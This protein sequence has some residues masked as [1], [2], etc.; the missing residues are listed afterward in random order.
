MT[1]SEQARE[2]LVVDRVYSRLDE[3]RDRTRAQLARVRRE[4][5]S[6]THQNR[7]ERDSFATLYS[8]RIAQLDAVE[9][10]LVF[11]RLD[12]RDEQSRY[13]GRIGLSDDE[14]TPVLTDWRAPAARPFYQATAADP[15]D[16]VRRR[17]LQTR[18]RQVVAVEDDV[19][20][21]D[22]LDDEAR[23]GLAGEGALLAAL[24]AHRT[25]RMSDIVAT[26]QA[27]QD[28]VIRSPLDG[29][30]VVQGG[31]GTG[32]TAVALHRAAY[33]LYAHR[34]RLTRS[35]V[36][37]LGPSDVFLGYISKV[38]PA[39]GETGVVSTTIADL[40]PGIRASA[41][42]GEVAARLKGDA[43][44]ARVIARAVRARQRVPDAPREV[45][46]G[47]RTLVVHP[48][49]V[50]AAQ[51]RARRSHAPHNT[52]RVTFVR[53]MLQTLARQYAEQIGA[54]LAG[55]ELA[56]VVED[57]RSARD[58]RVALNLAWM[59]LTAT[60]LVRDLWSRPDRLAEA[61]PRLSAA[62]REAL[63]RSPDAPWTEADVP[64]I[65]EAAELLGA[66]TE[67]ERAER[68][69]RAEAERARED[70]VAYARETIRSTGVGG[71]MVTAEM[72]AD[73]F[74]ETGPSL[75]TAE[76][77]AADR[78]WT[79]GHVVVDE[80]QELSAMAWR[81]ILRRCPSRSMTI[82]GDVAQ[83]SSAAGARSWP[84][85][86]DPVL[87]GQWRLAEL[88]VNYR[89]PA[90]I[91]AAAVAVAR[92]HDPSAAVAEPTSARDLPDALGVGPTGADLA[93][94]VAA[95]SVAGGTTAVIAPESALSAVRERLGLAARLDL[96]HDVVVVDP[97]TSKG[98][99]FDVVV[100]VDAAAM[101]RG[102]CYVAMTRATRRLRLVGALPE[103]LPP[104]TR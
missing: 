13:I 104:S 22:A 43:A 35:G 76:R 36:L 55:D 38:L 51:A 68:D 69:R 62:E 67:A 99:E 73:R 80:A 64:L 21:A 6:G 97:V 50:E 96:E 91:M 46:V 4:G 61:A 53:A 1:T 14:H 2:Q 52:A 15:G 29:V 101:S 8:D 41:R 100:L 18:A 82:V 90:S 27:E 49:D 47:S 84:D 103:G 66:S 60:G 93:E 37:L 85:V 92:A 12:L 3:L 25:G 57:I 54:D 48:H 87:R 39:L 95:E 24:G 74:V 11:G 10:Q 40:V 5:P 33:L 78:E 30:L 70:E 17:H 31:P 77:A 56:E 65:D 23:A 88:T 58:V 89:T 63:R 26:I 7:S 32:K 19:L 75:T 28:A 9:D 94:V 86:L 42:E 83:T 44:M 102:D 81:A 45:R 34:D 20:D 71:G 59:P 72:L 79:Y 98:L 16:V